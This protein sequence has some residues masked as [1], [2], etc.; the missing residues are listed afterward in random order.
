[1]DKE[2]ITTAGMAEYEATLITLATLARRIDGAAKAARS[3]ED[4]ARYIKTAREI[5]AARDKLRLLYYEVEDACKASNTRC[6]CQLVDVGIGRM[7]A[8]VIDANCPAIEHP[9]F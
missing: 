9:N 1:M 2:T 7:F 4:K 6:I 3:I 8:P 5:S